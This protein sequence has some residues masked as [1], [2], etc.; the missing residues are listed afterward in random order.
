MRHTFMALGVRRL[1]TPF[2]AGPGPFQIAKIRIGSVSSRANDSTNEADQQH[3]RA[4]FT[5]FSLQDG[6]QIN[7]PRL[8]S[9]SQNSADLM[10]RHHL[11]ASN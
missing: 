3:F 9:I 10:L 2:L 1:F 6:E 11:G 8:G 7:T 4:G 5:Y